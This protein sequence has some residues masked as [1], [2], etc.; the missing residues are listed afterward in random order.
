MELKY[1]SFDSESCSLDHY[2]LHYFQS[3]DVTSNV[4]LECW[5]SC[6]MCLNLSEVS[7]SI[8]W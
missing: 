2:S 4:N 6:I 3:Q 7:A 5:E 1:R 8:V